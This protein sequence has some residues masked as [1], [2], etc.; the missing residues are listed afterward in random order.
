MAQED[1]LRCQREL[2]AGDGS[3]WVI[4]LP[5]AQPGSHDDIHAGAISRRGREVVL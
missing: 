2:D 4:A 5:Q 1:I 3:V